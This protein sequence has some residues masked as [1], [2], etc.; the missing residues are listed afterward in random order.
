MEAGAAFSD[1][2]LRVRV[3]TAVSAV[4]VVVLF[5]VHFGMTFVYN[6]PINPIKLRTAGT[7]AAWIEPYFAQNWN[8]FAPKPIDE[9][10]GMLVRAQV[11]SPDGRIQVTRFY[12]M[13]T[14]ANREAQERRWW[15]SRAVRLVS[16]ALQM[17]TYEDPLALA[18]QE[19]RTR[20]L[21]D[22]TAVGS[23]SKP[24]AQVEQGLA[25]IPP[26]IAERDYRRRALMLIQRI[27]TLEAR[28]QFGTRVDAVQ[29]R[30]IRHTFPRFSQ[31]SKA[32]DAG[33]VIFEDL[34]WM[35]P[36]G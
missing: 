32:D 23:A 14:P 1:A 26:T 3:I 18:V 16:G 21:Q 29:V 9:N 10:R 12:D 11:R 36:S 28:R 2:P 35:R 19:T 15:P 22:R 20:L 24:G 4:F 17:L 33:P 5:C 6:S 8:L 25:G 30:V 7:V 13:T 31:R 34:P 27:A